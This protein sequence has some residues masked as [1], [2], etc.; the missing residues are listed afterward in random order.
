[1]LGDDRDDAHLSFQFILKSSF[2]LKSKLYRPPKFFYSN[3][4][5]P[6]PK[7][8]LLNRDIGLW[9]FTFRDKKTWNVT[10]KSSYAIVRT[11]YRGAAKK[12]LMVTCSSTFGYVQNTS[13]SEPSL[14][15]PCNFYKILVKKKCVGW[16]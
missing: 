12:S 6:C 4:G 1:M 2:G 9:L 16:L 7:W 13:G 14:P 10:A 15:C 3:F 8:I 11:V 5:Y